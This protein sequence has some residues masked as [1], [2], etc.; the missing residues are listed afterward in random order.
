MSQILHSS[1]EPHPPSPVK[2]FAVNA[3][4]YLNI[5]EN[6]SVLADVQ[7]AITKPNNRSQAWL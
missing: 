4:D 6:T 2:H 7:A 1:T 3:V 5:Y